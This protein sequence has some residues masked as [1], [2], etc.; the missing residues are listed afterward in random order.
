MGCMI[1]GRLELRPEEGLYLME[2]SQLGGEINLVVSD[3]DVIIS[4]Y[5]RNML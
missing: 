5:T 1:E 3:I 2:C 4:L